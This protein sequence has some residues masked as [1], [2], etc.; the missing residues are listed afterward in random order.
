MTEKAKLGGALKLP[1]TSMS[2]NRM[3]YGAM[4]LA[5]ERQSIITPLPAIDTGAPSPPHRPRVEDSVQIHA[6]TLR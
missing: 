3:G 6:G 5:C 4:Q 2:L 1:G